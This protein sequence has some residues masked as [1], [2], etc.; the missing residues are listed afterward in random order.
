MRLGV[1]LVPKFDAERLLR[2]AHL[3]N[4]VLGVAPDSTRRAYIF[5]DRVRWK[6]L[7]DGFPMET[8]LG[9][10]VAHEIGHHLLPREGHSNSG[11]MQER[12]NYNPAASPGFTPAQAA[13][14]RAHVMQSR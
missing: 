14:I 6:A 4:T 13:S 3:P 9:R 11:I 10:V 1:V 5:C 7:S 8:V 2:D 12:V